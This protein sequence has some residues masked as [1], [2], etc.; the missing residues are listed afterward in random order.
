[1]ADRTFRELVE[2]R[3]LK[4]GMYLGEFATPG[5]GQLLK[6]A[7]IDFCF[8]DM[9]HSGFTYETVKTTLRHLH[10]AGVA[11]MV[12]PP[13]TQYH[14]IARA[15]DVGAQALIPPMMTAQQ[16]RQV[17]SFIKYPPHGGRGCAFGIAHDDYAPGPADEKITAGN[18]KTTFVALIETAAGLADV[19]EIA[20]M[21]GVD[22][23]F[24]G[25]FDLTCSMGINAQFDHPDFLAAVE[26][27]AAAA[28]A[29]GKSVGRMAMT[30]A[31]AAGY[32]GDGFDLMV[33]SGDIWLLQGALAA[34]VAEIKAKAGG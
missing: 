14:H 9:E 15:C 24:I 30:P 22:A 28:K 27:I 29:N 20:A 6:S 7:G 1:M 11:S 32:Y 21:D 8:V 4:V 25:H 5:I 34:G 31:E 3:E 33:H 13:S 18:A 23:L 2:T 26:R 10:D 16:A 12:R 19:E 17:A